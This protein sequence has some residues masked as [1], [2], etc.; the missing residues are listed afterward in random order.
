MSPMGEGRGRARFRF[1]LSFEKVAWLE[2]FKV[3]AQLGQVPNLRRESI[4][5]VR[6]SISVIEI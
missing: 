1:S 5:Y 4:Y 6:N 3:A 2:E